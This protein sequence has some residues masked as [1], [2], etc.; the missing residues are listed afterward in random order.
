MGIPT[1]K[2]LR[3][4]QPTQG[5]EGATDEPRALPQK[6]SL[7]NRWHCC[8]HWRKSHRT[9]RTVCDSFVQR[10][11][12]PGLNVH[13]RQLTYTEPPKQRKFPKGCLGKVHFHSINVYHLSWEADQS[14]QSPTTEND[15]RGIHRH[16]TYQDEGR[17]AL[18]L[19][20][21][22]LPNAPERGWAKTRANSA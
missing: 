4:H 20:P 7:C 5:Q 19:C 11:P 21:P 2:G 17:G 12:Q 14:G 10:V 8:C 22:V 15:D 6:A 18:V 9:E 1:K 3:E 16:H 13:S